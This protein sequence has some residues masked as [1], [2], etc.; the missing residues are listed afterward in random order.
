MT[1]K[2]FPAL[3]QI[4]AVGR[5]GVREYLHDLATSFIDISNIGKSTIISAYWIVIDWYEHEEKGN[6]FLNDVEKFYKD[7]L[8]SL[9]CAYSFLKKLH[10]KLKKKPGNQL[11][12]Y[13]N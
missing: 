13:R 10:I 4:L 7:L 11:F 9:T 1:S 3:N 8:L 5:P 12:S 6:Y 2:N